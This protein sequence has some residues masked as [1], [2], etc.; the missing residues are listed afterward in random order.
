MERKCVAALNRNRKETAM[1]ILLPGIVLQLV[2]TAQ[3]RRGCVTM[4][5]R[6]VTA[7]IPRSVQIFMLNLQVTGERLQAVR[8]QDLC[9]DG[10]K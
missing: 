4:S 8:L 1:R 7:S 10:P 2:S 6:L 9:K 3:P 5:Q